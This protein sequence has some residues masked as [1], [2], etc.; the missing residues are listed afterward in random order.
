MGNTWSS[1]QFSVSWV[2]AAK[3]IL[4]EEP[5]ILVPILYSKYG[6]FFLIRFEFYCIRHHIGNTWVF[7]C[8][9]AGKIAAIRI[10]EEENLG[11]WKPRREPR[12]FSQ[13][14]GASMVSYGILHIMGNDEYFLQYSIAWEYV[15]KPILWG[16]SGKLIAILS[17]S[18]GSFLPSDPH[19]MVCFFAC[20]IHWFF[21]QIL[22]AWE[23][24]EKPIL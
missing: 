19:L 8:P 20:E 6:S 4:W 3:L 17:H 1:H 18:I 15:A 11:N 23:N 10:L 22:I 16:E 24:A 9:I 5:G 13:S 2:N 21:N 14:M 12:K 7:E